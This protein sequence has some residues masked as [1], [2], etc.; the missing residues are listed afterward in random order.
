M[1]D[2]QTSTP[3]E[4]RKSFKKYD[5]VIDKTKIYTVIVIIVALTG[6]MLFMFYLADVF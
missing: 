2:E 3:D 4:Y 1:P 5:I 6:F